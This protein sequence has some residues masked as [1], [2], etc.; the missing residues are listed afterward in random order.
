MTCRHEVLMK[1]DFLFETVLCAEEVYLENQVGGCG[2]LPKTLSLS[3]T[4]FKIDTL[5]IDGAR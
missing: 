5:F 2:P 1:A 3:D 4:L